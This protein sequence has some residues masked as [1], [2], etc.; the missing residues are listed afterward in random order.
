[1]VLSFYLRIHIC[2]A[3]RYSCRCIFIIFHKIYLCPE[4][5]L[6]GNSFNPELFLIYQSL[7]RALKICRKFLFFQQ[8]HPASPVFQKSPAHIKYQHEDKGNHHAVP[9]SPYKRNQAHS[10]SHK[11]D[12]KSIVH[13]PCPWSILQMLHGD[14]R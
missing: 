8:L 14:I 5:S 6:C 11:T 10:P 2:K 1:M 3:F 12:S 4:S 9:P 13:L 7:N